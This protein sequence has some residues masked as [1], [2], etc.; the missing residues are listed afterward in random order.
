MAARNI[1]RTEIDR[2]KVLVFDQERR[3]I[4]GEEDSDLDAAFHLSVARAAKNTVIVEVLRTLSGVLGETRSDAIQTDQR[5]AASLRTHIRIVDALEKGDP[6]AAR[7]AME[8]HLLEVEQAILE[9]KEQ[10]EGRLGTRNRT[11]R[12]SGE[13]KHPLG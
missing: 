7:Q 1:T 3:I 11:D 9:M 13:E 5:R 8:A 4:S 12:I 2:L 10:H 6:E